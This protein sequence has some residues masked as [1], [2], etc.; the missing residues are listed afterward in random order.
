MLLLWRQA[1]SSRQ[2]EYYYHMHACTHAVES[3]FAT[4]GAASSL[5]SVHMLVCVCVCVCVCACMCVCVYV[6]ARAFVCA[7][8]PRDGGAGVQSGD[9]SLHT[10]AEIH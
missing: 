5:Y 10:S 3:H 9:T 4:G 6:R 2:H 8:A 1:R 7:C